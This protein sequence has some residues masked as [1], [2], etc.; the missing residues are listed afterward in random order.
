L[1]AK[2]K[3]IKEINKSD[4][5][6]RILGTVIDAKDN[7]IVLDDGTGK[8]NVIFREN[9]N[10]KDHQTVRIFGRVMPTENGFEI[11]GEI[12]QDMSGIDINLYRKTIKLEK[13]I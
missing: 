6:V 13:E 4:V 5:R 3:S 2:E 8:V 7:M 9:V 1:P 12:I 10:V 11:E